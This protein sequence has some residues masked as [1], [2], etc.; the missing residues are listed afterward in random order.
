[1]NSYYNVAFLLFTGDL[2]SYNAVNDTFIV[3]PNPDI[4]VE[5]I[6]LKKHKFIIL[7][8]DGLWNMVKPQEAV[9]VVHELD[10]QVIQEQYLDCSLMK[11]RV[12]NGI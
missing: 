10:P 7:A 5:K 4:M 1:M 11:F 9:D 2:W 3:S 12:G 8:S 6:N